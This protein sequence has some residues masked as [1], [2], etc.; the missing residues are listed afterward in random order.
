MTTQRKQTLPDVIASLISG[1]A[2]ELYKKC[3]SMDAVFEKWDSSLTQCY[4]LAKK[5]KKKHTM[6]FKNSLFVFF[7]CFLLSLKQ[8]DT[9]TVEICGAET[10]FNS[11]INNFR[12]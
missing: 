1:T 11:S 3:P 12:F 7:F 10:H 8:K 5:K 4:H 2:S 6:E 9:H